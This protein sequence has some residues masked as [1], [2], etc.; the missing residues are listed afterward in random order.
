M[1]ASLEFE[2]VTMIA[3]PRSKV[4]RYLVDWEGLYRW[5]SELSALRI[6][7]AQ[8]EGVGVEGEATV[9]IGGITTRDRIRVTSWDPLSE[10]T[11]AHL[12]WVSGSGLMRCVDAPAG[13]T[14][15][16]TETLQP[17]L[18]LLGLL[19]M[20]VLK[21]LIRQTFVKDV[22]RLKTLVESQA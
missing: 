6:T 10:L 9:R 11:I 17:P 7:S 3:A 19:G 16:W 1:A 12:G 22:A 4:W 8:R 20:T 21:P 2:M 13:T 5:M 18:G 14:F 15:F